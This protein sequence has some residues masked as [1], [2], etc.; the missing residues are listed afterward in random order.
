MA[1]FSWW[2]QNLWF[3]Y[4]R[5]GGE[6]QP[7]SPL[8]GCAPAWFIKF[9]P[10]S[11]WPDR[12]RDPSSPLPI[13][14]RALCSWE[15]RPRREAGHLCLVLFYLL[16][17]S[18][19]KS[20]SWEANRYSDIQEIPRILW[21]PKVY[22]RINKCPPPSLSW[23]RSFQFVPLHRT[24]WRSILI[25]SYH[26]RLGL[27]SGVFPSGFHTKT[28]Y[29]PLLS[30][31]G[32]TCP[33]RLILL[34]F[35]ARTVLGEECR[36]LNSSMCSVLHPPVTSSLFDP[37]ILLNTLFSNTLSPRSSLN[38]SDQVSLSS[39]D[40]NKALSWSVASI[41]AYGIMRQYAC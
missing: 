6:V 19:E 27:P 37:N 20:P 40:E 24:T 34:D 30:P 32:A 10:S 5:L 4:F 38:V 35:I 21:N 39:T 18:M 29:T 31:T 2:V 33:V 23:A 3:L 36:S 9:L 16:T 17:Y 22:Y 11:Q 25:L 1:D 8:F 15:K 13:A 28:M 12:L 41:P 14:A 26:L 7:G